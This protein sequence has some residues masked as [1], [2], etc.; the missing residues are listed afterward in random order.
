MSARRIKRNV[1]DN[2]NGYEGT[3]KV[4]EFGLDYHRAHAWLLESLDPFVGRN[5]GDVLYACTPCWSVLRTPVPNLCP[6]CDGLMKP[7]DM[8]K[9]EN[10]EL[11]ECID[12]GHLTPVWED[13]Q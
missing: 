2:W 4:V 13:E 10:G 1:W 6:E 11:L 5:A 9:L 3:H 12:C 8:V 7:T